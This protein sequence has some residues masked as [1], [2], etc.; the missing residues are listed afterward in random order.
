MFSLEHLGF[1]QPLC[2]SVVCQADGQTNSIIRR[3]QFGAAFDFTTKKP[4][5]SVRERGEV[6][7]D[8]HLQTSLLGPSPVQG[9]HGTAPCR[10]RIL[11]A[12]RILIRLVVIGRAFWC[13]ILNWSLGLRVEL[14]LHV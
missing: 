11:I 1:L 12:L 9:N 8:L 14:Q 5:E 2:L 3:Q 7:K 10:V 4:T 6:M 13:H